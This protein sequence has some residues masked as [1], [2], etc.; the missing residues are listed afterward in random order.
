MIK[1][2]NLH[3][4]FGDNHVL[5]GIDEEIN[6]GEVVVIIGPS[7][8]GKSTF[9]RCLNHLETPSSGSI[10]VLGKDILA[11]S[12]NVP[13]LRRRMG[14]VFQSFNLFDSMTILENVSFA[15]VKV[16]GKTREEA[17]AKAMELL[18]LVGMAE[19]A[20]FYPSELSGGQKQRVAIARA[21]AMEPEIILFDEPTSALDPTMVSEVLGV[22]KTLAKQ[23]MTMMI[24]THEMKFARE[25]STRVFYMDEGIIYESGTPE[26]IF[27]NPQKN[28]TRKF[29]QGIREYRFEIQTS[30]Y[31]YYAMMAGINTFC[32]RYNL[33][34]ATID[35]LTHAVEECLLITG[36]VGGTVVKVGYSEKTELCGIK[37]VTPR[38]LDAS[39]LDNEE[40]AVGKAIL[41][42]LCS[43]LELFPDG[44]GTALSCLLKK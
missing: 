13:A 16:L 36:T 19:R 15:P 12:S 7:G 6:K 11:D 24:V 32:G 10:L 4:S 44:D 41:E 30:K 28:K 9:L 5:C 23:G 14:M 27:D 2:N 25:V 1:V 42:G 34:G 31:D 39:I 43:K 40:F 35:H 21:L 26:Q 17:Q 3:K 29:I 18:E 22:M 20:G 38:K 33:S 8:S 37:I